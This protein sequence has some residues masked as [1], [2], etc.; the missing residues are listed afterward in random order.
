M[1]ITLTTR[2]LSF[3]FCLFLFTNCSTPKSTAVKVPS[4]DTFLVSI[5][6]Q[7]PPYFNHILQS[8][9]SFRVQIIYTQIDRRKNNKPVFTNHYFN[10]NTS[11][12][13]YP[14][15][16]VKLPV[17][18]LALQRLNELKKKG[19][20]KNTSMITEAAHSKQTAVY[21]DPTSADGK[22]GIGHYIKKIFLVSDNDAYNRLYEFLGPAYINNQLHKKGYENTE[23]IHR[24]SLPMT[25]DENRHTNPVKFMD[26]SAN[27]LYNQPQQIS[28][29]IPLQRSDFMGKGFISDDKLIN[30]PFNFSRKNR[31]GLQQLHTILQTVLF[32]K[33]FKAKQRFKLGEED[34]R[35]IKQYLSQYPAETRFPQ[36]DSVNHWDAYCKFLYWGAEKQALPKQLR[37]FNKVGNAYGFLIDVA[38]I[39]DLEKNIEFMLSAVIYCNSD[40]IFNDDKYDYETIGFPFMKNIGR[41][42]YD[43]ELKRTRSRI[44]DL[45]SFKMEY[46]K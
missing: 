44:P 3:S 22:P 13:F 20:D 41:V 5:L 43:Y 33:A 10:N 32:P 45:T 9:D 21:N 46:D 23:I 16:T 34:Y 36:Y 4:T 26:D 2:L 15:S 6:K 25:E 39:A 1:H 30:E 19:I 42:I 7:H 12:Y 40:G 37:I 14:A 35:F 24:L 11:Q 31:I 8:P 29:L 38:Y 18:L 27:I 17:A 28:K